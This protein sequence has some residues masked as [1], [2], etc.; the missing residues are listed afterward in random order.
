MSQ[1]ISSFK[2]HLDN[3]KTE[4][5]SGNVEAQINLMFKLY[6]DH[7]NDV[8]ASGMCSDLFQTHKMFE[9]MYYHWGVRDTNKSFDIFI[10]LVKT[11]K[12]QT[13]LGFVLCILGLYYINKDK[14]QYLTY[15]IKAAALDNEWANYTL[16][17]HNWSNQNFSQAILHYVQSA[18]K[19]NSRALAK[20]LHI[21]KFDLI[22][23]NK[24]N[25]TVILNCLLKL[26]DNA[27][28]TYIEVI[29]SMGYVEWNIAYHRFWS[30]FINPVNDTGNFGNK[31]LLLLLISKFR[32][33]STLNHVTCFYKAIAISIIRQLA[34]SHLS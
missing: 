22:H 24:T 2:I 20:L 28:S 23:V 8:V 32:H 5:K 25:A 10:S 9:A 21:I 17:N 3:L 11:E 26:N 29:L 15:H 12:N 30:K 6:Y 14:H 13:I 19:Y 33:T 18:E 34:W 4:S 7:N 31:T 27:L 1:L 16:A